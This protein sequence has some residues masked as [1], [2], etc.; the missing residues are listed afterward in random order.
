[1]GNVTL[2]V[3]CATLRPAMALCSSNDGSMARN[4]AAI[5]R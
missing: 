1:M 3:V 5:I 4:E 2:N